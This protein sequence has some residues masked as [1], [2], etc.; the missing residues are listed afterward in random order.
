MDKHGLGA[1]DGHGAIGVVVE[2]HLEPTTRVLRVSRVLQTVLVALDKELQ[3][4]SA[5]KEEE[6]EEE[7]EKERGEGEEGVNSAQIGTHVYKRVVVKATVYVYG[8]Q[9]HGW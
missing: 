2:G 4:E 1:A 5:E 6:E 3:V 7:E 8:R 9:C